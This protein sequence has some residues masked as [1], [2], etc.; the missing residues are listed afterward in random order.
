MRRQMVTTMYN[1]T[2]IWIALWQIVAIVGLCEVS[3]CQA[4]FL[5]QKCTYLC[6]Y[7]QPPP[8]IIKVSVITLNF[9]SSYLGVLHDGNPF[10]GL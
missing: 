2:Y 4:F 3:I 9:I 7:E 5:I 6:S 10:A 1:N 8:G